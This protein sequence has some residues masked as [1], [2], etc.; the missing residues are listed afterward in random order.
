MP[1]RRFPGCGNSTAGSDAARPVIRRG[2]E[3]PAGARR[4]LRTRPSPCA[5]GSGPS[6][7]EGTAEGTA[8]GRLALFPQSGPGAGLRMLLALGCGARR[9]NPHPPGSA[10][11]PRLRPGSQLRCFLTAVCENWASSSRPSRGKAVTGC[12]RC[13][14]WGPSCWAHPLPA[15]I[16]KP[17]GDKT[18]SR[19]CDTPPLCHPL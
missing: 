9:R 10:L 4:A 2:P 5:P 3:A 7:R 14:A 6:G 17:R 16:S 18:G 8:E 1:R 15:R 13:P 11:P 19:R 12:W